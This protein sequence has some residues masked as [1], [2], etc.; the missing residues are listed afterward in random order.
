MKK[1]FNKLILPLVCLTFLTFIPANVYADSLNRNLYQG[2]TENTRNEGQGFKISDDGQKIAYCYDFNS[3]PPTIKTSDKKTY[4]EKIPD[5]LY[6][7]N[8]N[9]DKYGIKNKIKIASVLI[10]GYPLDTYKLM[11]KY[12]VTSPQARYVTQLLIWNINKDNDASSPGLPERLTKS[13]NMLNYYKSILNL[14]NSKAFTVQ[15]FNSGKLDI[16]GDFKFKKFQNEWRTGILTSS[17]SIGSFKFSNL[18]SYMKVIDFNTKESLNKINV[19]E[20][21]YITSD[22]IPS[23]KTKLNITFQY[24]FVNLYFYKYVSGGELYDNYTSIQ[25]LIR[26]S[27]DNKLRTQLLALNLNNEKVTPTKPNDNNIVKPNRIIV[28]DSSTRN[29]PK[30]GMDN[31]YFEIGILNLLSG[32]LLIF[33]NK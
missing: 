15:N 16:M 23:D 8:S 25:N 1:M 28:S 26:A 10:L 21:F 2:Y 31:I 20:K 33:K 14:A 3:A 19:G 18:P 13:K 27:I 11:Q 4:Y 7:N 24:R 22:E 6:N 9:T 17:G 5:Y 30:T 12:N 29:L 32:L